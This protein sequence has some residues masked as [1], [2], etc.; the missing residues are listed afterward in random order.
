MSYE[1]LLRTL[2]EMLK[3]AQRLSVW[4]NAA[5]RVNLLPALQAMRDKVAQPGRREEPDPNKPTWEQVCRILGITPAQV[6]MWKQRTQ[7]DTDIRHLLGEQPNKPGKST[8]ATNA[9]AV[10]HLE[11]LCKS[12]L[13]G[14][15]RRA[16]QLAAA[17]AERYG[18]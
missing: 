7:T 17:I 10:K 11:A 3:Q 16:E 8:E 6:R 18:F 5:E 12:V 15:D 14:D 2:K 1:E 9:Q 13:E 4:F